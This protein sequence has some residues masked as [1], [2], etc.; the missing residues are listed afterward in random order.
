MKTLLLSVAVIVVIVGAVLV[1]RD[2]SHR[3]VNGL[4]TDAHGNI[5]M[6]GDNKAP[7]MRVDKLGNFIMDK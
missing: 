5:I 6:R 1:T 4:A 2:A 3:E 7:Q